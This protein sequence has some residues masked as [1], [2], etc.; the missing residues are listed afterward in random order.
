MTGLPD[1]ALTFLQICMCDICHSTLL[2]PCKAGIENCISIDT[3]DF[4]YECISSKHTQS[5]IEF[6]EFEFMMSNDEFWTDNGIF[7]E[8]CKDCYITMESL[9]DGQCYWCGKQGES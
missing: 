8:T 3:V 1:P 7:V 2:Q 5:L 6:I 9:L 4:L